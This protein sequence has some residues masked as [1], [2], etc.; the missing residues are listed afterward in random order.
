MYYN[1]NKIDKIFIKKHHKIDTY[2]IWF[3]Y[4]LFLNHLKKKK[5]SKAKV[6]I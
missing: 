3:I 4:H 5:A 6:V 1:K 2:C